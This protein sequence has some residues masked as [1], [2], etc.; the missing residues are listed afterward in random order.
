[1]SERVALENEPIEDTWSRWEYPTLLAIARWEQANPTKGFLSRDQVIERVGVEAEDA[2][3]VGRSL[4]RLAEA[5]LIQILDVMDG[6]PW[7]AMVSG[8]TPAGLRRVGAWPTPATLQAD[9]IDRL[10]KAAD[11]IEAD[12]PAKASKVREVAEVLGGVAS[13]VFT[14]VIAEVLSKAAGAR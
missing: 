14:K 8:L 1:M 9:F 3:K 13:D 4:D 10:V 12:Q 6:S 5:G 11:R 7:P 2:W